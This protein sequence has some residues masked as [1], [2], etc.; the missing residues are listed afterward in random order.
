MTKLLRPKV[1]IPVVVSVALIAGLLSFA[2]APRVVGLIVR[3]DPL[4]LGIGSLN[5][6]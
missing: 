4:Y 5:L 6:V 1:I 3:L 2:D